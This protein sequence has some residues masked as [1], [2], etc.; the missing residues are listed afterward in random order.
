[1]DE[2]L[3]VSLFNEGSLQLLEITELIDEDHIDLQSRIQVTHLHVSVMQQ[4]IKSFHKT[5]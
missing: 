4:L 3:N 2:Q 5:K 1:M